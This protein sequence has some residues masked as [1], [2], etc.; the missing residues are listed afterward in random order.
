VIVKEIDR[1]K[2][3]KFLTIIACENMIKVIDILINFIKASENTFEDRLT[4]IN[5]RARFVNSIIDRIVPDQD[6]NADLN[7]KIESFYE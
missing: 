3:F 6:F 7:V 2:E 4:F 5:D 1:R